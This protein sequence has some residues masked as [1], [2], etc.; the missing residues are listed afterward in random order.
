MGISVHTAETEMAKTPYYFKHD[1]LSDPQERELCVPVRLVTAWMR[2]DR[3]VRARFSNDRLVLHAYGH[4]A[5]WE[6]GGGVMPAR[7]RSR[8]AAD[9]SDGVGVRS[10]LGSTSV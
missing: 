1:L 4:G 10:H 8:T 7:S 9:C 5:Y 3:A 6:A 2:L